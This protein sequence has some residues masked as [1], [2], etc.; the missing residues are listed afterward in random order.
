MT[1]SGGSRHSTPSRCSAARVATVAGYP[2]LRY[3]IQCPAC[4]VR[5]PAASLEEAGTIAKRHRAGVVIDTEHYADV[6]R[7]GVP[8]SGAPRAT[9]IA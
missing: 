8:I 1:S 7:G 6:E 4:H 5:L 9:A 3:E 2:E